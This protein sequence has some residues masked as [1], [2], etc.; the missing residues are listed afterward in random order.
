VS[1]LI[2]WPLA[3][4]FIAGGILGGVLGAR[5][6]KRLSGTTGRLTTVFAA[7]IFVVAGYMLWESV[8]AQRLL[9]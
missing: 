6:A 8:A 2:D 7:V 4:I 3:L 5:V 9:P 1:G